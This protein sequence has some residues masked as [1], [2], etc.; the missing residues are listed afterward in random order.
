MDN[1]NKQGEKGRWYKAGDALLHEI[2][3]TPQ[4]P[5]STFFWFLG[6][7]GFVIKLKGLV[8]YIDVILNDLTDAAGKT[9]RRYAPAFEPGAV[10][11]VDY[12]LC[13]HD[14]D[15]HLNLRTLLPLAKA[16][17]QARFIVPM[18][19]R[20]IL[21]G[22]GIEASRVIGAQ[23][24]KDLSLPGDVT[25]SPVA[26]AHTDYEQDEQGDYLCL[27]YVLTG[28]GIGIYHAGDTLVTP[29]LVET[30]KARRPLDVGILPINGGDWERT[31]QGIIGNMTAEDAVKFARAVDI[32][33]V[34]P[35]HY[36]MMPGNSENP[37]SFAD[38]M[39]TLCPEK[40]YH[41]FALGER[42]CYLKL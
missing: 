25:V 33:L 32:D 12:F 10:Q 26:A 18:P 29:R 27:G 11:P 40:K 21:I 28:D 2:I 14:H 7:L 23:E 4:L 37:A 9:K 39:Y 38:Y 41:L 3:E 31:S 17:P 34:I 1:M 30:L 8:F 20:S 13:T 16:N 42:L 24:G 5:G 22:A 6:Q 36:D 35:A 19:L 15:D